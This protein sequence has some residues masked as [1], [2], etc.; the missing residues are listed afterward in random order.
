MF[1]GDTSRCEHRCDAHRV[2]REIEPGIAGLRRI[3]DFPELQL[4]QPLRI[5]GGAV[6]IGRSGR[7]DRVGDDLPLDHQALDAR[8]DEA[9]AELRQIENADHHHDQ[10]G[11]V[12]EDDPPR[13]AGHAQVR[14]ELPR[15]PRKAAAREL[16]LARQVV[17]RRLRLDLGPERFG[18]SIEHDQSAG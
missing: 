8:I 1:V 7:G 6:G 9:G 2:D 4:E 3:V 15:C 18:R 10:T 16:V 11:D 17:V 5:D 12:E 14:E 13:Q